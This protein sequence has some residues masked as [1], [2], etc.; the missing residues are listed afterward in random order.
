[1]DHKRG[2]FVVWESGAILL[3]LVKHYDPEYKLWSKDDNEQ[4]NI[5]EWLFFQVSGYGPYVGQAFWSP[6]FSVRSAN[7]RFSF[8]HKEKLPS[9]AERYVAETRR[10]LGV[11]ESQ[12]SKPENKGY[13]AAG[14]YTIADLSFIAWLKITDRLPIKLAEEYPVVEKWLQGMLSRSATVKGYAGGPY[15]KKD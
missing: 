10:V 15:G 1:V 8:Y 13:L 2:D 5:L 14:K 11:V 7:P 4:S 12:L 9:A 3:Y 6:P